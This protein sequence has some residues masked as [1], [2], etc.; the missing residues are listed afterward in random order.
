[1]GQWHKHLQENGTEKAEVSL[2][3]VSLGSSDGLTWVVGLVLPLLARRI[4]E[5]ADA[6]GCLIYWVVT[7]VTGG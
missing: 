7:G 4:H 6:V 1:M 3:T 5:Y 2:L